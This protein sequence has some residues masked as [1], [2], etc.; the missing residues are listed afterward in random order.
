MTTGKGIL[1]CLDEMDLEV[2]WIVDNA[3]PDW[4]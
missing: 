1:W 4:K 2:S 3:D